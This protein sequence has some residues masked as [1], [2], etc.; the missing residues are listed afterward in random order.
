MSS[1]S[2][3]HSFWLRTRPLRSSDGGVGVESGDIPIKFNSFH[4]CKGQV[5]DRALCLKQHPIFAREDFHSRAGRASI[6]QKPTFD[7]IVTL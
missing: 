1:E 4:R 7:N 6:V 5:A 3:E 2:V